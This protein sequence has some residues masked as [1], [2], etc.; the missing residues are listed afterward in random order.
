MFTNKLLIS[1]KLAI[2]TSYSNL[3]ML[4]GASTGT[5]NPSIMLV[6]LMAL[7]RKPHMV[8]VIYLKG[9][10]PM[11]L[12]IPLWCC[13]KETEKYHTWHKHSRR[14]IALCS[15]NLTFTLTGTNGCAVASLPTW[16]QETDQWC[17]SMVHNI[18]IL[19][20]PSFLLCSATAAWMLT[21]PK[22]GRRQIWPLYQ[23]YCRT[24]SFLKPMPSFHNSEWFQDG[25]FSY[26]R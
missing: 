24:Q 10:L 26:S 21:K 2:L 20:G 5:S 17:T 18:K 6:S 23:S 22:R 3:M 14:H 12:N 11:Q 9:N 1:P 19:D 8:P 4:R 15:R 7:T 13:F 16:Q 25:V